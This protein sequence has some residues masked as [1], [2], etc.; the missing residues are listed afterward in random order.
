MKRI[1]LV[2]LS[3][4]VCLSLA[5]GPAHAGL[6][7]LDVFEPNNSLDEAKEIDLNRMN[8]IFISPEEDRDCFKLHLDEDGYLD[9]KSFDVPQGLKPVLKFYDSTR[10]PIETKFPISAGQGDYYLEI[11]EAE[12]KSSASPFFVTIN[13][14]K[15]ADRFEP[16]NSI[17]QAKEITPG[18]FYRIT[19]MPHG[20]KDYFKIKVK[21][22]GY[23]IP[24][25][26]DDHG[27]SSFCF[28]IYDHKGERL[29]WAFKEWWVG[30]GDYYISLDNSY[31]N[32]ALPLY[33]KVDLVELPGVLPPAHT[34]GE[35][36]PVTFGQSYNVA[37]SSEG[38]D[39]WF[40][41]EVDEPGKLL[42]FVFDAEEMMGVFINTSIHF[43]IRDADGNVI[44]SLHDDRSDIE[45]FIHLKEKGVYFVNMERTS[46]NTRVIIPFKLYFDFL[47]DSQVG[48]SRMGGGPLSVYVVGFDLEDNQNSQVEGELLARAGKGEFILARDEEELGKALSKI[49]QEIKRKEAVRSAPA[50]SKLW[51]ILAGLFLILIIAFLA[52][53]FSKKRC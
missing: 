11:K 46:L 50:S 48:A 24:R 32:S 26:Q 42:V 17:S 29:K 6:E 52:R 43:Y 39:A 45:R 44:G 9:V 33:F 40:K 14:I 10:K 16:N 35:A 19:L 12:G 15:K 22:P 37:I 2:I 5:A 4:F 51:F 23:L 1:L 8:V 20:D 21:K 18:E 41:I 30:R 27:N 31:W 36:I 25:L 7:E 49:S 53:T 38:E 34:R 13:F 28:S 3:V 47:S